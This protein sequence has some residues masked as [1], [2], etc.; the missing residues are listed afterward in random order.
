[1]DAVVRVDQVRAPRRRFLG[2]V[3]LLADQLVDMHESQIRRATF[4]QHSP[5]LTECAGARTEDGH[6][7]FRGA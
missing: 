4:K 7:P 5:S 3:A 1:M 6:R 2:M